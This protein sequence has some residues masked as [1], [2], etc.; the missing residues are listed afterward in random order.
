M[1]K[2]KLAQMMCVNADKLSLVKMELAIPP[3]IINLCNKHTL[4]T[5]CYEN[6]ARCAFSTGAAITYG[7]ALVKFGDAVL[8]VEHCWFEY[9]GK[10][11]DPTYQEQGI[12]ETT[13]YYSLLSLSRHDYAMAT[14]E[15]FNAKRKKRKYEFMDF[16]DL[17]N[18]Q[19]YD[20][21]FSHGRRIA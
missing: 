9:L 1:D 17:R 11:Y 16:T 3:A 18:S 20:D 4:P 14:I 8:P 5:Q 10:H 12:I 6:A 13:Q 21:M 7:Y 2:E 19:L 15:L